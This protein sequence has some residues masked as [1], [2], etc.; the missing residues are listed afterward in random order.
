MTGFQNTKNFLQMK[1]LLF[2][3]VLLFSTLLFGC[4]MKVDVPSRTTLDKVFSQNKDAEIIPAD[5]LCLIRSMVDSTLIPFGTGLDLR[6]EEE[7]KLETS[8]EYSDFL[9]VHELTVVNDSIIQIKKFDPLE[10]KAASTNKKIVRLYDRQYVF[11]KDG[12]IEIKIGKNLRDEYDPTNRG[13]L[14]YAYIDGVTGLVVL[15]YS[16]KK[17]DKI[18]YRIT[19][20]GEIEMG[21]DYGDYENS[22]NCMFDMMKD[23]LYRAM[24][25]Y[26]KKQK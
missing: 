12:A 23:D 24:I 2:V 22:A 14:K 7:R 13:V 25:A 8:I 3:S 20:K 21:R 9:N 5:S 15:S 4:E 16:I 10:E 19:E 6:T 18:N 1:K 26:S 17:N 11:H